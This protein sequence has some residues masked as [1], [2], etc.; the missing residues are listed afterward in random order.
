[1]TSNLIE[2][3]IS[4]SVLF[5]ALCHQGGLLPCE[6]KLSALGKQERT[7]ESLHVCFLVLLS[8]CGSGS[9][10]GTVLPTGGHLAMSG[11]I[12]ITRVGVGA[13]CI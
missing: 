6:E 13:T 11:G 10:V 8:V 12:L 4:F 9:H 2:Q 7:T 5:R 3:G 1:M